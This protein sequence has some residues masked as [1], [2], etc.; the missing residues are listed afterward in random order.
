MTVRAI[1]EDGV[2]KPATPVDLPEKFVV[3]LD[4]RPVVPETPQKRDRE[5]EARKEIHEILSRR[6]HTCQT[7]TAE[8]HNEHQP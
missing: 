8:R 5:E 4:A 7:D 2:F 3:E 1:Y 6:Y